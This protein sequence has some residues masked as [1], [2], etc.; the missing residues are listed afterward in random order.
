M[1]DLFSILATAAPYIGQAF[2]G[3]AGGAIGGALGGM[4][5]ASKKREFDEKRAKEQQD[6]LNNWRR[7]S[8]TSLSAGNADLAPKLAD[9]TTSRDADI[10]AGLFSGIQQGMGGEK[11]VANY[12]KDAAAAKAASTAAEGELMK[13]WYEQ[14]A[15]APSVAKAGNPVESTAEFKH[16]NHSATDPS[17]YQGDATPQMDDQ[18]I[19]TDDNFFQVASS[20]F[21]KKRP[22]GQ[23]TG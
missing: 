14:T 16:L 8:T 10:S 15:T 5:N 13:D 19:P 23:F 18:N 1:D 2:G 3:P 21:R 12:F 4:Y 6:K 20:A 7:Y 9:L 11:G 22:R 17:N